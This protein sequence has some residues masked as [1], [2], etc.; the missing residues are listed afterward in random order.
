MQLA[1]LYAILFALIF[2]IAFAGH[3]YGLVAG[4]MAA[5]AVTV[6]LYCKW[7]SI[8]LRCNLHRSRAEC[9]RMNGCEWNFD[10]KSCNS[11]GVAT[12]LDDLDSQ[13]DRIDSQR[14]CDKT[15]VCK[16][17]SWNQRCRVS[18]FKTFQ[19]VCQEENP[20]RHD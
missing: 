8:D 12:Y 15:Q 20:Y 9:N 18:K 11:A 5:K 19:N 1:V 2:E 16:W 14:D 17:S 6:H 4:G 7:K 13:C 3:H 10:K